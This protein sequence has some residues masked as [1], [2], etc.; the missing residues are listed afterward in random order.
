MGN[1]DHSNTWVLLIGTS[2]FPEDPTINPI[3]NVIPNINEFKNVLINNS[4]IGVPETNIIISLNE[5]KATIERKLRDVAE[6]TRNRKSTL[7]VYYTGHG[8]LSS[9]DYKL[10]LTTYLTSKKDLEIEGLDIDTFKRYIKKSVAG[11]KIVILDCCHSGAI[12]GSMNDTQSMIQASLNKFEGTYVMTSTAE[13]APSLFPIDQPNEPTYFTFNLLKILKEGLEN[14]MEYCSLR[15]IFNQIDIELEASNFPR[16][17][18]SNFNNADQIYFCLN[19]QFISRKTKQPQASN[20]AAIENKVYDFDDLTVGPKIQIEEEIGEATTFT[21]ETIQ[22]NLHSNSTSKTIIQTIINYKKPLLII[23]IIFIFCITINKIY[24]NNK[25][26]NSSSLDSLTTENQAQNTLPMSDSTL[27]TANTVKIKN[28]QQSAD[29]IYSNPTL[30]SA[31]KPTGVINDWDKTFTRVEIESEYPGGA[32][33]WHRFL[34]R[35]LRYPQEAIDNEIQGTVV[36]QFIVDK[37]GNVSDVEAISGPKE[38]KAESIL[39]IRKS[40]QWTPAVQNGRQVRSY[41]KQPIVFRLESE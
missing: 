12:I 7:L 26:A 20:I 19:N 4:I 34:N 5:N 33:A 13:D 35:N 29:P 14:D 8:I 18:Q 27:T 21:A 37:A 1:I 25:E 41:K 28:D 6:K 10:Y 31:D 39:M 15:D 36:V 32:A 3:P 23:G 30:E 17:Q 11:R 16:P 24:K 2:N 9:E 22:D 40:G 38:L